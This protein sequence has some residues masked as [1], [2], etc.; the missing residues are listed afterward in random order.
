[1]DKYVSLIIE[2][3]NSPITTLLFRSLTTIL[4]HSIYLRIAQISLVFLSQF[5]LAPLRM[6]VLVRQTHNAQS[7]WYDKWIIYNTAT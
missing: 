3:N 2:I 6:L 1:M 7:Q 5:N 4:E